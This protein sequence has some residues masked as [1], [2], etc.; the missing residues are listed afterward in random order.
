MSIPK[1]EVILAGNLDTSSPFNHQADFSEQVKISIFC[2]PG[3]YSAAP[4]LI[5]ILLKDWLRYMS[6]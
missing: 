6:N 5:Y 3:N 4:W 1:V 2:R